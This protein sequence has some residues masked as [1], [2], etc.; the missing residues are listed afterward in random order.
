MACP[1]LIRPVDYIVPM[2]R[3]QVSRQQLDAR[4]GALLA[5]L[6]RSANPFGLPP[7]RRDD[8]VRSLTQPDGAE[9]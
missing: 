5:N 3:E 4:Q 8:L 1:V 6:G 2:R 7:D 9:P